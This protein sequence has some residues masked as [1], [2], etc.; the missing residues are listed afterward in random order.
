VRLTYRLWRLDAM[1]TTITLDEASA[2][3][4]E[5]IGAMHPGDEIRIVDGPLEV[6]RIVV[7]QDRNESR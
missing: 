3:L 4:R 1:S 5:I 7:S 2:K 6:A